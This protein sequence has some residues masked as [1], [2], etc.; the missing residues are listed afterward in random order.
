MQIQHI[1]MTIFLFHL[2][3]LLFIFLNIYFLSI[4]NQQIVRKLHTKTTASKKNK[5][6]QV[7]MDNSNLNATASFVLYLKSDQN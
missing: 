6:L 4:K 1:L 3:D 5:I 2:H 7:Q